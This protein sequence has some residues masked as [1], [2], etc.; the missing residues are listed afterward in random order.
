MLTDSDGA[1]SYSFFYW[2]DSTG[3]GQWRE[4][5]PSDWQ[6][7]VGKY[8]VR[9]Y[10]LEGT[11]YFSTIDSAAVGS[12]P[13]EYI[14]GLVQCNPKEVLLFPLQQALIKL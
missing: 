13:K 8:L 14:E 1:F 3:V 2:D 7:N 4:C 5:D 11:N 6:V 12:L 10:Q 9:V